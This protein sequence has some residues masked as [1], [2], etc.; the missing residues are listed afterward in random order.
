MPVARGLRG[1]ERAARAGQ[2]N[3]QIDRDV[4]SLGAPRIEKL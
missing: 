3:Q 4:R 2:G 1:A